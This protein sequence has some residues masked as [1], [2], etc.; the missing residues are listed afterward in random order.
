M[1]KYIFALTHDAGIKALSIVASSKEQAI[2]SILS[3]E[4]CPLKLQGNN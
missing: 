3:A 4:N 2:E 1:K